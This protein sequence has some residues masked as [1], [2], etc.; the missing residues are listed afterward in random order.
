MRTIVFIVILFLFMQGCSGFTSMD[1]EDLAAEYGPE[2]SLDY[3]SDNKDDAP[4]GRSTGNLFGWNKSDSTEPDLD[5]D[6]SL[7]DLLDRQGIAEGLSKIL[8][9]SPD[10]NK[11]GV[12]ITNEYA[13]AAFEPGSDDSS[14]AAK[15]VKMM[16]EAA[17][18]YFFVTVVTDNPTMIQDLEAFKGMDAR[19]SEGREAL[20]HTI[21]TMLKM[22]EQPTTPKEKT[23]SMQE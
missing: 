7:H 19:S 13:L 12:L 5:E 21:D 22:T 10:V 4:E 23:A 2:D 8:V 9:K 3:I 14:E 11:A 18:P 16:V 6:L 15:R 1:K 20:R 17:V